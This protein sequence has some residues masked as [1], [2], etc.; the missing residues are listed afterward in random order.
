MGVASIL[1]SSPV[2]HERRGFVTAGADRFEALLV[3]RRFQLGSRRQG[4]RFVAEVVPF[5][6][7]AARRQPRLEREC[8]DSN[9]ALLQGLRNGAYVT[10]NV[11]ANCVA[12]V[13]PQHPPYPSIVFLWLSMPSAPP[14]TTRSWVVSLF[15]ANRPLFTAKQPF[16]LVMPVKVRPVGSP[17]GVRC[18]R[19][20]RAQSLAQRLTGPAGM[21]R[22]T[23]VISPK[24]A[25]YTVTC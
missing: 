4:S 3:G 10:P 17:G 23:A 5:M 16:C 19:S 9:P 22:P 2:E 7:V 6:A 25:E 1:I 20:R 21:K 15:T 18:K 12:I 24:T 14:A 8:C 11:C 13:R